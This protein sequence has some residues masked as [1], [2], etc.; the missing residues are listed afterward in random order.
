MPEVETALRNQIVVVERNT[1]SGVLAFHTASPIQNH[2]G[3]DPIP[4][5]QL[6]VP[7]ANL[8]TLIFQRWLRL[9]SI[10]V[11][12]LSVAVVAT[13]LIS[14]SIIRPLYALRESAVKLAQGEFSHRVTAVSRDEIGAVALA[15]NEMADQV[16]E[17]LE[18]QR[19]FASNTSHELRTPLT[20]IRLRSEA[21]RYDET[22]DDATAK[23][24]VTE[25]DDEVRHLGKLVEDLT[26]LSRFD[27]GR[28]ELGG[29][30]IDITRFAQSLKGQWQSIATQKGIQLDVAV[31]ETPF[32]VNASLNH[33]T[34]VFRN[35]LDNAVKY[36]PSGGHIRWAIQLEPNGFRRVI[37]DSGQGIAAEHLPHLFERF[38]RADK[39]RSRHIPGT[40]L[41]LAL[42]KSIVESYGGAVNVQSA[43]IQQGTTVT[44]FWP[45]PTAQ[46]E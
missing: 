1:A 26:L 31:P 23:Q 25:I 32:T 4:I 3:P 42:V 38:Y 18:E 28:A 30:E 22:L 27:A 36:T 8:Q 24:Y 9:W 12:V 11:G 40:G 41:G 46:T 15:F 13:L 29:S 20:T 45:A 7:A 37:E 19:A 33:L 34:V 6:S 2:R 5:V 16:Q 43:G 14:R 17:M 39:A 21:L 10:F 44:V 35:L